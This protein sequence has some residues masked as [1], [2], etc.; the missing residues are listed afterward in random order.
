MAPKFNE[1]ELEYLQS[2]SAAVLHKQPRRSRLILL[3]WIV[4]VVVSIAWAAIVSVE[5]IVRS[6]GEVIPFG[7]N[8]VLQNLE[9]GIV[10]EIAIKEGDI[11]KVNEVLVKIN[12]YKTFSNLE[13]NELKT[14]ELKSRI[15]RLNAEIVMEPL[16]FSEELIQKVPELLVEEQKLYNTDIK[17][18]QTQHNILNEQLKQLKQQL[19]EAYQK[20][21]HLKKS[22]ALI[23]QEVDMTAP[24]V[25]KGIRSKIDYLKLQREANRVEDELNG[26]RLSIPRLKSL[27]SEGK[28]K[29]QEVHLSFQVKARQE[30]T[31]TL[32]ELQ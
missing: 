8:Q 32:A 7:E 5:E 1:H 17:Q 6:E 14:F 21:K 12:N 4:T 16:V 10:E 15:R 22:Y 25:A 27:V 24:M 19:N 2:L 30:L 26:V 29:L 20:I 13:T 23:S 11:V 3:L 18:M 28:Q 31:K 9:G